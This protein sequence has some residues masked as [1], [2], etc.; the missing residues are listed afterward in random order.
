MCKKF[1]DTVLT[2]HLYFR[3]RILEK[4]NEDP[5][6]TRGEELDTRFEDDYKFHRYTNRYC[7]FKSYNLEIVFGELELFKSRLL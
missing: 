1:R 3:E 2:S 5:Y 6:K 7:K 4:L